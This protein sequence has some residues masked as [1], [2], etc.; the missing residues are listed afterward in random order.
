MERVE[1]NSAYLKFK[2]LQLKGDHFTKSSS[3]AQYV[4]DNN[5]IIFKYF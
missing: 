4:I 1:Q 2:L 3:Q 5:V